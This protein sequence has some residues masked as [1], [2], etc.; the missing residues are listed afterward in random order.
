MTKAV[1]HHQQ[2]VGQVAALEADKQNLTNE[3]ETFKN[4]ERNKLCRGDANNVAS[5][6]ALQSA[7]KDSETELRKAKI[8]LDSRTDVGSL[9]RHCLP[10][11]PEVELEIL[12]K[13][14]IDW[15]ESCENQNLTIL[16]LQERVV[17]LV[18]ESS[19]KSKE[20]EKMYAQLT[21]FELWVAAA[22]DRLNSL[23]M[24]KGAYRRTTFTYRIYTKRKGGAGMYV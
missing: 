19:N 18:E 14:K 16:D 17:T 22:Q 21:E 1:E 6:L 13:A 9:E 8:D 4:H 10:N 3:F 23:D 20:M 2:L 24:E 15:D 12:R 11:E 5:D 7:D